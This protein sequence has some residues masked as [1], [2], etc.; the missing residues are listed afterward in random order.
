MTRLGLALAVTA[1][2]LLLTCS[3]LRAAPTA[4]P[5]ATATVAA[6]L[7]EIGRVHAKTAFCTTIYDHGGLAT[8]AALAGDADLDDDLHWLSVVDLDSTVLAKQ[9]GL[10]ELS[11][12]YTILHGRARYAIDESK[13]LRA[14]A[15]SAPTVDQ[16]DALIAYADALGGALHR[17][18]IL[19]EAISRLMNYVQ[20]HEPVSDQQRDE[21]TI[22]ASYAPRGLFEHSLDPRDRVPQSLSE[23]A[24]AASVELTERR[25]PEID[26]ETRA[27][28]SADAAFGSCAP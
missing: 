15:A 8:S 16:R 10:G 13:A 17:Q 12:R 7:R 20:V 5:A 19:A 18:M 4:T 14:A 24:K 9:R 3:S 26:D 11:K 25:I 22:V 23:T 2:S 27:A 28:Q 21:D 6:P 1:A